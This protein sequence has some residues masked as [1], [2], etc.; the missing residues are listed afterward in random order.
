MSKSKNWQTKEQF[1]QEVRRIAD[2][3]NLQIGTIFI[4]PMSRKWASITSDG[5]TLNFSTELLE[6]EQRYGRY[7]IVHELTHLKVPNHGKLF[8]AIIRNYVKNPEKV[9]R[10]LKDI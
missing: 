7:V 10:G 6:I 1:K 5:K 4:R 9:K 2:E 8:K 3:M